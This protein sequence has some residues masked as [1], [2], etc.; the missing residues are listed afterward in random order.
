MNNA[1]GAGST[2]PVRGTEE[3]NLS[4]D[5]TGRWAVCSDGRIGLIEGQATLPWGRSWIGTGIDGTQWASRVPRLICDAD[6]EVL[7][8]LRE[9]R[10]AQ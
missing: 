8:S 10:R 1:I 4:T 6:A 2:E 5:L 9:G 7:A 3:E